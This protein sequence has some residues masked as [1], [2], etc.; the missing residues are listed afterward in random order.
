M[1]IRLYSA[2]GDALQVEARIEGNNVQSNGGVLYP[3]LI[4]PLKL[5]VKGMAKKYK[6]DIYAVQLGDVHGELIV[7]GQKISDCIS[8]QLNQLVYDFDHDQHVYLEFPLNAQ[9]LEWIEQQ[10]QGS[11]Q[12]LVRI[13]I[14]C[15]SLGKERGA[16]DEPKPPVAFRDASIISGEIPFTIPDTQWREKVLPGLGYGKVIAIELPAVPIESIQAM[17]H[18]YK[19]L[20]QAQKQFQLGHYDEAVGKCRVALEPFFEMVEKDSEPSKKIPKLKK[21]WET[22]LGE[23]TYRWLDESLGAIKV[24]ANKP[25]HSPN[26]HFDRL[27]AQMLIMVT[28][29]L[30]SY[31]AR[32]LGQE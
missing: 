16:P 25:H 24:A 18:S 10:R 4:I 12:G 28:T 17:E 32:E 30:I 27:G 21:S 11:M 26:V 31:A 3:R 7:G 2:I 9:T 23:S 15:L 8:Y 14:S 1:S 19:A 6:D 20:E 13:K 5:D 29:A 22:K